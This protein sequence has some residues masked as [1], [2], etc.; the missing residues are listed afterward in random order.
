MSTKPFRRHGDV[1]ESRDEVAISRENKPEKVKTFT[2]KEPS[3]SSASRIWQRSHGLV[4]S[5]SSH[6]RVLFQFLFAKHQT[7]DVIFTVE[8]ISLSDVN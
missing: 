3:T 7:C 5:I 4:T 8:N 6:N 2:A 1:A